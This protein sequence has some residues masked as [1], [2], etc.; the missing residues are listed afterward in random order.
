MTKARSNSSRHRGWNYPTPDYI[1]DANMVVLG[2]SR[3]ALKDPGLPSS[4]AAQ[5]VQSAG[6]EEAYPTHF[7]KVAALGFTIARGHG[8]SDGNKRTAYL[9]M[10]QTLAWNG[11][12]LRWETQTLIVVMSAVAAGHMTREGLQLALVIGCG[13]DPTDPNLP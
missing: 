11:Y 7:L 13:L 5:P 1:I 8:F 4:A 9:I 2:H 3:P 12:D 10:K 6:G